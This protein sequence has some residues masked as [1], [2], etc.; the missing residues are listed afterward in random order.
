MP[1][2]EERFEIDTIY[3]KI[4]KHMKDGDIQIQGTLKTLEWLRG[5]RL[6]I[7]KQLEDIQKK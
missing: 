4:N 6:I 5:K 2:K 7:P 3:S 1:P